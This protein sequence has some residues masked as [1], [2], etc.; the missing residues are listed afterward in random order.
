MAH[1][2]AFQW[3]TYA[4][5]D[6]TREAHRLQAA[7]TANT[8]EA[9]E[10]RALERNMRVDQK[11]KNAAWSK[12]T[13]RRTEKG[14]RKEKKVRKR[15]WQKGLE[16]ADGDAQTNPLSQGKRQKGESD[17]EGDDWDELAR[18]E[19]LAKKVKKGTLDASAFDAE[20]TEL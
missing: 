17:E 5:V 18:E 16:A 13:N 3:N 20:F 12:E 11:E 14:R 10:K 7:E 6:R 1:S 4:Y 8:V 2:N 15:E 9:K 19:R